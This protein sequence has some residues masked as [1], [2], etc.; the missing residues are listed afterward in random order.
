MFN[1]ETQAFGYVD[2]GNKAHFRI[3]VRG[4]L[5]M[6]FDKEIIETTWKFSAVIKVAHQ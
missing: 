1:G 2:V 5:W 6:A 3:L 4:T